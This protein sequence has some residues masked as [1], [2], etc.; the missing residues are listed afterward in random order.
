[1]QFPA[2]QQNPSLSQRKTTTTTKKKRKSR[3]SCS[4]LQD[5]TSKTRTSLFP[6][7]FTTRPSSQDLK[8]KDG[9]YEQK[10]KSG[11]Q[12]QG[13]LCSRYQSR[14]RIVNDLRCLLHELLRLVPPPVLNEGAD[15]GEL[16]RGGIGPARGAED[17][18]F[19]LRAVGDLVFPSLAHHIFRKR[20]F[21]RGI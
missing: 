2:S 13:R 14:R 3:F 12:K 7:L 18:V 5:R 4:K 11:R 19:E 6:L 9:F 20:P 10:E 16:R 21:E 8:S 15:G 17:G 1:M